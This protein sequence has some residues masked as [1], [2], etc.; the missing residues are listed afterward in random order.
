MGFPIRA[1]AAPMPV[2]VAGGLPCAAVRVACSDLSTVQRR[3]LPRLG[4]LA[5]CARRW[6][7]VGLQACKLPLPCLLV[8]CLPLAAEQ[9]TQ[10]K[11]TAVVPAA[12]PCRTALP[13]LLTHLP[14]TEHAKQ[15]SALMTA[16]PRMTPLW[17]AP[18]VLRY[19]RVGVK[20]R[21]Q[22]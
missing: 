16:E 6:V 1:A 10:F 12:A 19:E 15:T 9:P 11:L 4:T 8:C 2:A 20:V 7:F 3:V 17:A 14:N 13:S 5:C 22:L 21:E 18:E